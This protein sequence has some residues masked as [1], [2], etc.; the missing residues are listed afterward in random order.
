MGMD[1]SDLRKQIAASK[2]TLEAYRSYG[3]FVVDAINDF[4][5]LDEV[6][7][8]PSDENV[9]EGLEIATKLNKQIGPYKVFVPQVANTVN[10]VLKW[11]REN[12]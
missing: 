11:L 2:A 1:A 8:D 10:G 7:V 3:Q 5:R 6:L 9:A 12:K 4:T